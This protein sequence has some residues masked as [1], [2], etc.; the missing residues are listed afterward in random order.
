MV[1]VYTPARRPFESKEQVEEVV[2]N[3]TQKQ[4]LEKKGTKWQFTTGHKDKTFKVI[5]DYLIKM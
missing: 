5:S 2:K 4:N 3:W 1:F